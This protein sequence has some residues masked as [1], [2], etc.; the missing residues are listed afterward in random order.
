[1]VKKIVQY[2]SVAVIFCYQGVCPLEQ[3]GNDSFEV[4]VQEK[5][6]QHQ[7]LQCLMLKIGENEDLEKLCK[8]IKFDLEFTDQFKID[9][10]NAKELP[11]ERVLHKLSQEGTALFFSVQKLGNDNNQEILVLVKDPSS[12]TTVFEKKYALTSGDLVYQ[13]HAISDDLMPVLCG[14]KGPQ[15]ST[16]AYCKQLAPSRKVL[17]VSDYAGCKEKVVIDGRT[18]NV[19]PRWHSKAP[20]LFF[21]QFTRH[22]SRL[23]S[24]DLKTKQQKIVCSYDG[25]NMQPSFSE[26]GVKAVLCFSS[27]GNSELYL[28]DQAVCSKLKRRVF[29]KLTDN[30]GNNVSP[31]L[32]PNGDVVFCSDFEFGRPQ[33]YL[34]DGKTLETRRI[35]NGK[36]YCASPSFCSKTNDIIYTRYARGVFQL[37]T[38]NLGQTHPVE[39]Q[40]TFNKGDKLEPV[41]SECGKYVA[42]TFDCGG[43]KSVRSVRQIAIFNLASQKYRVITSGNEPKSY[44]TW[45]NSPLYH[46]A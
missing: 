45:V 7:A 38:L 33:L 31:C 23:M 16:L 32:L 21:S 44:P 28:Y 42:F 15:M 14:E 36:G 6:R 34:L 17:C 18:I 40:L 19:A 4:T 24:L 25:L 46:L 1:M 8:M 20:C 43:K 11:T 26:D 3:E 12:A 27:K 41:W 37:F 39:K 10:K 2:M 13:G 30:K 9:L 22:N 29:K 5:N 35:S